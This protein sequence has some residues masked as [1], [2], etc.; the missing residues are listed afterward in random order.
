MIET[1]DPVAIATDRIRT[2][3]PLLQEEM[4]VAQR[5]QILRRISQS[6][7]ISERTLRR[8]LSAYVE[9]G[10]QGLM[11]A[12][13][14][15]RGRIGSVTENILDEAVILRREVPGRSVAQIIRILEMEKLV[16]PGEIKRSTLQDHLEKRGYGARQMAMF[17]SAGAGAVRRFAKTARNSLW[18]ADIKYLLVLPETSKRKALQLY[19]SAFIDDAT[20]YVVGCRVYDKQNAHCVLDC[21]RH[22]MEENGVPDAIFTDNGKQYVGK[23]INQVCAKL[24]IK[25]LHARPLHPASK[26]KIE[27][28]NKYLDKFVE[29]V[30]LKKPQ[31]VVEVE[32]Y[33]N[34]WMQELYQYKPHSALNG[35]TPDQAFRENDR[36]LRYACVDDLNF[37]FKITEKRLVDKTGCIS[38]RSRPWEAGQDLIGM[39]VDVVYNVG[40]PD[41]LE[42]H[43]PNFEPRQISP[44]IIRAN[45]APR[46]TLPVYTAPPTSRELDA[47]VKLNTQRKE[48]MRT[49]I[50]FASIMQSKADQN[51]V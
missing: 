23:Q 12:S 3:T 29:E 30:K 31:S 26:G 34:I 15:Y 35:K 19:T 1:K 41:E 11:P 6:D 4:D 44:L 38:F 27:A 48:T 7:G 47:A 49:A 50:S 46:K 13:R 42:I 24:G 21:F 37:A 20:R 32:H 8:W 2:L 36:Q 33:L 17:H 16:S 22:A 39:N 10:F 28:F 40:N 14:E 18:Q 5:V 9:N 25:L 51:N 45:S 43:H